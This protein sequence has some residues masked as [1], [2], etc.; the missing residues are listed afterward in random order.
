MNHQGQLT[1][2]EVGEWKRKEVEHYGHKNPF[3]GATDNIKNILGLLTLLST[4]KKKLVT[5]NK[6]YDVKFK[7]FKWVPKVPKWTYKD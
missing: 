2:E 5:S 1:W 6:K 4:E 7:C 3:R